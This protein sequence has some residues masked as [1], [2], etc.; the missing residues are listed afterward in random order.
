MGS[1]A[2]MEVNGMSRQVKRVINKQQS[3]LFQPIVE[4]VSRTLNLPVS[5]WVPDAQGQTLRIAASVGLPSSYVRKAFLAL[6]EPSVT[7]EAFKGGKVVE[8]RD[9]LSD[10]HWKYKKQALE[11]GWKSVLCVP[12]KTQ[13]A[14]LGV[15]SIYT[16][17]TREFS[18]LEKQLLT[19]Y[20]TQI[21]LALDAHRRQKTLKRLLDI[22]DEFARLTTQQPKVA[23]EEIVKGACEVIGA[24]CAVIYPYDAG[25][26]EFYD[27]ESVAAYGLNKPLRLTE[28]PRTEGGMA[29][30]VKRAG[31]VIISNI[32]QEDPDMLTSRF[33]AR[34]GIKAFMGIALKIG[35]KVLGILYVDFR[36]PHPFS[37]EEKDI[38]RLFAHQA[39]ITMDNSRLYQQVSVRAEALKRLH[40]VGP[41][42]VSIPGAPGSL[43]TTLKR[44]VRNARDVLGADLVDLY[45]YI[46]SRDEYVLPPVQVGKRYDL[47]VRKDRVYEDDVVYK[48]VRSRQPQYISEAQEEPTLTQP[49]TVVR[50]D[51]PPKRFVIR[52]GIKSTAIVPLI[53]GTEVVG[54]LFANY[55]SLQTFPQ[56]QQELIELLASQAAIAIRNAR[57]Y[58][59]LNTLAE[60]GRVLT[61]EIR[62][63]KPEVLELIRTQ[64][65]KLMD[66]NNMYIALY[67]KVTDTVQFELA[68]VDSRRVDVMAEEGWQPRKAGQGRTEEII[69]TKNPILTYTKAEAETWYAQPEHKNYIKRSFASWVGV[70]MIVG[71][72][73]LGVIATYHPTRDYVYSKDD[74]A[75]LQ[76]MANVAAIALDNATLYGDL[77]ERMEELK[78]LQTVGMALTS[79]SDL[80]RLLSQV[81]EKAAEVL[82]ADMATVYQ[83]D[84]VTGEFYLPIVVG[85]GTQPLPSRD[86]IAAKIV[87]GGEFITT[88]D[89]LS[90]PIFKSSAFIREQGVKS[91][92]AA[93]LKF[94]GKKVGILFI[95]YVRSP[96]RFTEGDKLAIRIFADQAATAINMAGLLYD[97]K[98]QLETVQ[99]IVKAVE[100]HAKLPD[101]LQSILNLTLSKIKAQNGT[102]QLFDK[103]T[104]ELVIRARAGDLAQGSHEYERIPLSNTFAKKLDSEGAFVVE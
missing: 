95:N 21:R 37:N 45:Q 7:G 99:E 93:P 36:T 12:I 46:Q 59:Q 43:K 104:N 76:A 54:V 66:T 9:V 8:V 64:A 89:P 100:A 94:A 86:G 24:D 97:A 70:P 67:D 85:S 30:Y 73:V 53:A 52:E 55:R 27:T 92:A 49:Y 90:H 61:H 91:C 39:A 6:G 101:Y 82:E 51:A 3:E 56:H 88:D 16:F 33:I 83:Y 47:S 44:I 31:E 48:V 1:D 13:D 17:V 103:A 87:K 84:P 22:G 79:E 19:D 29:A 80:E 50:P 58:E 69:H 20:A 10:Q 28:K 96:H 14:I 68:F 81:T 98:R 40:E 11:M 32:E 35:D 5:I 34:E 2:Q 38:V 57:L 23:L 26:E 78:G 63:R 18:D 42:L 72:K 71:N 65:S 74:L 25:R 62:L 102:I 4:A 75:I 15:I 60:V 41:T 77:Q